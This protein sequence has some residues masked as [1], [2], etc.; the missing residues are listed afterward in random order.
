MIVLNTNGKYEYSSFC[1]KSNSDAAERWL[2]KYKD[3][4]VQHRENIIVEFDLERKTANIHLSSIPSERKDI[5][6]SPCDTSLTTVGA[7]INGDDYNIML[8]LI[9]YALSEGFDSLG[10]IMDTHFKEDFFNVK[11]QD[12]IQSSDK[13]DLVNYKLKD[14]YE[15][16]TKCVQIET[17]VELPKVEKDFCVAKSVKTVNVSEF[18]KTVQDAQNDKD[19]TKFILII[20]RLSV[21]DEKVKK[22]AYKEDNKFAKA[23]IFRTSAPEETDWQSYVIKKKVVTPVVESGNCDSGG[24]HPDVSIDDLATT[25]KDIGQTLKRTGRDLGRTGR[26][27]LKFLFGNNK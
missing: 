26:D 10:G 17:A 8:S 24:R 23:L 22:F 25:V 27:I 1:T 13:E 20:T 9:M 7:E 6:G 11:S 19:A 2:D 18:A 5:N 3:F 16:H 21:A 14:L 15:K 12:D 4:I